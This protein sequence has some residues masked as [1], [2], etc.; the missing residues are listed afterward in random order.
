VPIMVR[1]GKDTKAVS[2]GWF[3]LESRTEKN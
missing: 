1:D 2:T 3:L